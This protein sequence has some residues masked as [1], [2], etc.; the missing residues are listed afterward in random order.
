M[1]QRKTIMNGKDSVS[2]ELEKVLRT[3]ETQIVEKDR[4]LREKTLAFEAM[5]MESDATI[6]ELRDQKMQ[7]SSINERLY[8][9]K[10]MIEKERDELRMSL[11]SKV[12]EC[13]QLDQKLRE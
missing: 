5:K 1:L 11:S 3:S 7:S 10:E 8:T 13:R 4:L 2:K 9:A 12:K 6:Q